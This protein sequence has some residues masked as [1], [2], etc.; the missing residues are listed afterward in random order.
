MGILALLVSFAPHPESES[1]LRHLRFTL[2]FLLFPLAIPFAIGYILV[3]SIAHKQLP[4]WHLQPGGL[5]LDL[6]ALTFALLALILALRLGR[7]PL[8]GELRRD[9]D[10]MRL[11]LEVERQREDEIRENARNQRRAASELRKDPALALMLLNR[12]RAMATSSV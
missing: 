10:R 1:A 7:D 4:P 11:Q 3:A 8:A 9:R 5:A 12:R 6:G 2:A